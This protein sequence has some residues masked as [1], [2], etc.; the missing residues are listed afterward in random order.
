MYGTNSPFASRFARPANVYNRVGLETEV[1]DASPHRLIQMLWD[2][3]FDSLARAEGA[4]QA[5]QR[6]TK[7]LALSK[8]ARIL[9]EG[10][11]AGLDLER[12]GPLALQLRDLYAYCGL[13]L[14]QANLR[15]DLNALH[16][17]RGLLAP[18]R[19]AWSQIAPA[20]AAAA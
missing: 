3:L 8:A 17:V 9:D 15:D 12:G 14:T 20:S 16:E 11:K 4:I 1:H 19:E 18:L 7:A 2:G 6:D 10:L 13:R 5:G